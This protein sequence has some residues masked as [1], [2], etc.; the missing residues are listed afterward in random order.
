MTR[1]TLEDPRYVQPRERDGCE[2]RPGGPLSL[3]IHSSTLENVDTRVSRNRPDTT[4]SQGSEWG[5]NPTQVLAL[6]QDYESLRRLKGR[7]WR[8]S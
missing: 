8:D 7:K 3:E 2:V 1:G 5:K 4:G 6:G